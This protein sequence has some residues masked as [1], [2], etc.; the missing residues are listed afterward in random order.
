MSLLDDKDDSIPLESKPLLIKNEEVEEVKIEEV[1]E[2]E[3][4]EL[5]ERHPKYVSLLNKRQLITIRIHVKR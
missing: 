4:T 5:R 3:N 2:T 1:A